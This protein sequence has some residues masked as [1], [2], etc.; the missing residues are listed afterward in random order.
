MIIKGCRMDINPEHYFVLNDGRIIKSLEELT[1]FLKDMDHKTFT[2]HVNDQ[3]NDF[4]NWIRY[5]FKAKKLADKISSYQYK[6]R[7]LIIAAIKQFLS[8]LKI[9]VINAGSSSLKFQLL[10]LTTRDILIKGIIDAI[11]LDRCTLKIY[12]NGEERTKNVVVKNHEEAM[13]LLIQTLLEDDIIGDISEIRAVGHRVVHGGEEYKD[14]IRIDATVLEKLKEL[15][16]LAPLHNP[17]N[18]SC[19]IAAQKVI[20]APQ[21]AV[22]DTAFH[23]TIQKEKYL[24]GLPYEY[25]ENYKIRKY[26]FHGSSHKYITGL[27]KEY[28]AL[29]K[30][31]K[32]NIIICHLGNGS[33]ITAIKDWKS[34]NTTMGFTPADGLVMGTRSGSLDPAIGLH[35]SQLIKMDYEDF[36]RMINKR[37]GLLGICGYSDMRDLHRNEKDPKIKLAMDIFADRAVHF[38]GAYIAELNGVDGIVFTAGIGENAFYI[39]KK[40]LENFVYLGLKLDEKKNAASEFIITRKDSKIEAFVVATNEEIQI[41]TE[42]KKLLKL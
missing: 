5:V 6:E 31:K 37:S 33:S 35:L 28:Y 21:V 30:K 9:L 18:V 8:E 2:Y 23:A 3:K 42:V 15:S 32:A 20:P 19:I 40:I 12:D 27:M 26:G 10:E 24:Y 7:R 14:A 22:F 29:K 4:S 41:A 36:G 34:F 39:R 38:I 1:L 13:Q 11:N 17:A 16:S 25:Y